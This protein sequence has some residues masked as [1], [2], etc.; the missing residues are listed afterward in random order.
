MMRLELNKKPDHDAVQTY[1]EYMEGQLAE[2]SQYN[3]VPSFNPNVS[4]LDAHGGASHAPQW[5]SLSTD[6]I[7]AVDAV[8]FVHH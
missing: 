4:R 2:K 7:S 8:H 5:K 1:T 6:L 3:A